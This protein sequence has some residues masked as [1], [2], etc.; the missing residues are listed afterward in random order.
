MTTTFAAL[1]YRPAEIPERALSRGFAVALGGWDVPAPE[2]QI[3]QLAG[4][5]GFAVAFYVSGA[6]AADAAEHLCDL[7]DEELSPPVAV[8]DA[9]AELGHPEATVYALVYSED[10]VYDDGWRFDSAGFERHFVRDG[11]DGIESGSETP[12]ES[13]VET[14]A[15]DV[16]DDATEGQERAIVD[17]ALRPHRG[18]TFLS[19]ALGRPVLPALMRSLFDVE[20][21]LPVRFVEPTAESITRETE[22]LVHVLD[23]TPRRGAF[24]APRLASGLAAPATALAFIQA[25]DWHDPRDPGD[26][27]R[28]LAIGAVEGNLRFLRPD[29]IPSFEQDPAWKMAAGA[30]LYPVAKLMGSALGGQATQAAML[31]VGPDGDTLFRV[32]RNRPPEPAGPTFGELLLYLSLGWS[33]RS[34]AQEDLIGALMLRARLRTE[35]A[36]RE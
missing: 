27:Y 35:A 3:A 25:Y 33:K 21:K 34:D 26:L 12:D 9:A 2:L 17:S 4:L 30:P 29:E 10:F 28:E 15:V 16:P 24:P 6:A 5:P 11:E 20:R 18:T 23:R 22:T 19:A 31:A 32:R 13:L 1:L 14:L 7:F 8:L 36:S